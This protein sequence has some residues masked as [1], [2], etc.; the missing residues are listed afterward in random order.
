MGES[1]SAAYK[2]RLAWFTPFTRRSAIGVCS[3]RVVEVLS[4]SFDV[5]VWHPDLGDP[6]ETTVRRRPFSPSEGASAESLDEYAHVV[7]NLGN[8]YEFHGGIWRTANRRPGVTVLHDAVMYHF[9]GELYLEA[10]KDSPGFLSLFDKLYGSDAAESVSRA[11]RGL[12]PAIGETSAIAKWSLIEVCVE[13]ALGVVVHSEYCRAKVAD[14]VECPI[15]KAGLP[16]ERNSDGGRLDRRSLGVPD[17]DVL[18]VIAGGLNRNKRADSVI[19]ALGEL[20]GRTRKTTLALVGWIT[21]EETARL[22]EIARS[23]G[24]ES[25]IV[26]A[27]YTSD[28]EFYSYLAQ[29]DICV[30]LRFPNTEG[31]SASVIEEMLFDNAVVVLDTGVFRELPDHVVSRVRLA[32]EGQ[33]LVRALEE[34]IRSPERRSELAARARAYAEKT[35]R[36]DLYAQR[37]HEILEASAAASPLLRLAD[38][39]SEIL[40]EL[41]CR[42]GSDEVRRAAQCIGETFSPDTETL[43]GHFGRIG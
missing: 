33:D 41:G 15:V 26:F 2:P 19:R 23:A 18:V 38:Q 39:V 34:L 8:N 16:V 6:I 29:A 14:I 3:K 21:P 22:T 32:Y 31:A 35:Y 30:N 9:F 37:V 5:E 13:F 27:G 20:R 12:E 28:E 43:N 40:S 42:R 25:S 24:V 4:E 11:L 17:D 1:D 36:A 7:Y 10:E